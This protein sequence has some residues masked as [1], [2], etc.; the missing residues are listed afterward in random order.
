MLGVLLIVFTAAAA[1]LVQMN[2]LGEAR[3]VVIAATRATVQLAAVSLIIVFVLRSMA[4]TFVFIA[5][6]IFIAAGTAA[7]RI[8]HSYRPSA[9]WTLV[10]VSAAVIPILSLILISTVVPFK[11]LGVLPV[12][13][14]I[15][16]GTMTATSLAGRRALEEL[17][18][19]KGEYE[20]ALSIGLSRR[21][22]VHL[23]GKPAAAL[24]L[25]PGMDQTRTV[26]VVTLPG[27]FVG[28]LLAGASP[29]QAG[30]A[31]LL[32]LIS[33]LLAAA[34]ATTVTVELVAAG[35]IVGPAGPLTH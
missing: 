30:T 28:V 31:Q 23:I 5:M 2:Q 21:E 14:I 9:W 6:M 19:R 25:L 10:S 12:A 26:G 34:V 32:V 1:L 16:G 18:L 15:I 29:L 33:L 22:A 11:P 17:H 7:G 35:F 4:W 24:A 8:S 20:A 3:E 27:A 13:G